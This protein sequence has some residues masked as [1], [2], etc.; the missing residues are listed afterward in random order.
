MAP[1]RA[2]AIGMLYNHMTS[3]RW[4]LA[5]DVRFYIQSPRRWLCASDTSE[6]LITAYC[7]NP[8]DNQNM[9]RAE[10]F[11]LYGTFQIIMLFF[12]FCAENESF[13]IVYV[14][15][16][17]PP[18]GLTTMEKNLWFHKFG[19]KLLICYGRHPECSE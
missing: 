17:L 9:N 18:R 13:K 6:H 11:Y 5:T 4:M 3:G 8:Q 2:S 16:A 15:K 7:K 1:F 12:Y 19:V 10:R 14:D